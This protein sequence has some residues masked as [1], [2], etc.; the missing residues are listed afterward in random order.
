V[1]LNSAFPRM[2]RICRSQSLGVDVGA[3]G[4]GLI[5]M[6]EVIRFTKMDGNKSQK[7][8]RYQSPPHSGS[9]SR[10]NSEEAERFSTDPGPGHQNQSLHIPKGG[11]QG[12]L[13][14]S[15]RIHGH[16]GTL[17][18][19]TGISQVMDVIHLPQQDRARGECLLLQEE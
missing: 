10:P 5:H 12:L 6:P 3:S 11:R 1:L 19:L 7:R 8:G 17:L 13:C 9:Q 2:P 15:E 16:G 4:W 18:E 14:R